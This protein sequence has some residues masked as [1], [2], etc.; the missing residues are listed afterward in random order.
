M[1]I[2]RKVS[3]RELRRQMAAQGSI[4]EDGLIP[5]VRAL[6]ANEQQ[7]IAKIEALEARPN[8]QSVRDRFRWLLGW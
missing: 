4:V 8:P 1:S 2:N 5:S 3:A 6:L 7:I